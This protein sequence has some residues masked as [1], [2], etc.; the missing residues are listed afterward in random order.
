MVPRASVFRPP[1]YRLRNSLSS[2]GERTLAADDVTEIDGIQVTVPIRTACDL[3]R[4]LHRDQ[5]FAALDAMMRLT[6]FGREELVERAGRFRGYRGIRQ[7]RY[8]AP[9]ADGR[10]QSPGESILRLR[11]IECPELPPP[12]PQLEVPG[13]TGPYFLDLALPE[14]RYAAEYDGELW[15]GPERREHDERR[16][17]WVRTRLGFELQVFTAPNIHGPLQDADRLLRRGIARSRR[18][19]G[20]HG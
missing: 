14:L 17:Q 13:P 11:W 3:G 8:L 18:R 7:L 5:A 2:S 19:F 1:G 4:L 12:T 16:R 10:A 20:V 6:A 9:L 15:H